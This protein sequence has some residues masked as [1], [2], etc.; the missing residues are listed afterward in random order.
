MVAITEEVQQQIKA[1]SAE[2]KT[3]R[4]IAS[5]VGCSDSTVSKILRSDEMTDRRQ[6]TEREKSRVVA[7]Y[8]RGESIDDIVQTSG[9][10]VAT[11]FAWVREY[12][13]LG[14]RVIRNDVL[15]RKGKALDMWQNGRSITEICK[16]THTGFATVRRWLE[17]SGEY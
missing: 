17:E 10:S 4:H 15:E 3:G 1:L 11:I 6:A 12:G 7:Q 2:G 5:I 14:M 8:R 9:R 16:V 13:A